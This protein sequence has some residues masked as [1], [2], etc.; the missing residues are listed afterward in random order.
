MEL[1]CIIVLLI[2]PG[3]D[4]IADAQVLFHGELHVAVGGLDFIIP[5][6]CP[7]KLNNGL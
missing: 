7:E 3:F 2:I 5:V 1:H 6:T 4:G